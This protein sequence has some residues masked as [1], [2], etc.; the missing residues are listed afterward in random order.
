MDAA[1]RRSGR[2]EENTMT[3]PPSGLANA[4]GSLRQEMAAASSSGQEDRLQRHDQRQRRPRAFLDEQHPDREQRDVQIDE[5]HRPRE[6]GDPVRH[7]QLN[8]RG[9]P[10]LFL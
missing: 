1:R 6:T 2:S 3:P 8:V 5:V 10:L 4:A 9:P 7:P